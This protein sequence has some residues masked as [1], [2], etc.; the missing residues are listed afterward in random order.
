MSDDSL[1]VQCKTLSGPYR[2]M[3]ERP[4]FVVTMHFVV[5]MMIFFFF[6][7]LE[8]SSANHR[9][10]SFSKIRGFAILCKSSSQETAD[11]TCQT[12]FSE[13]TKL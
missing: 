6:V 3:R 2:N 9:L 5:A 8:T 7:A 10:V 1:R 13:K 4:S 11:M 12:L